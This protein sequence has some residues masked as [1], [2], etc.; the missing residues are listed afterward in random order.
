MKKKLSDN[1]LPLKS[2]LRANNEY[3]CIPIKESAVSLRKKDH[4][5]ICLEEN[6]S[7]KKTNGFEKYELIH[8]AIPE[9]DLAS[10]DTSCWFLGRKFSAPIFI[11]AM[12]GGSAE[13]LR[14]NENLS[15][16]AEQCGIGMGIGSQ[17]AMIMNVDLTNTYCVRHIAPTIFLAGNIGASQI[18]EF[19]IDKIRQA[20]EAIEAD[21]LAI[22]LNA[23][24]E[25]CQ[26]EGDTDWTNILSSIETICKKLEIPV[27]AK[28]TGCG[29]SG[30]VAKNLENA[31]VACI[32]T[33]GAG[34]TSWARVEKI[35]G[36]RMADHFIEW[37]IPTADSL[38]ECIEAV[39][40]PV[41]ASGGLRNGVEIVKALSLGATLT[42]I[43]IPFLKPAVTSMLSVKEK[44]N[45]FKKDIKNT[46]FLMGAKTINEINS[47]NLRCVSH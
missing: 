28:E 25:L 19:G 16:A 14:I 21:A 23:T 40:I 10:I 47:K 15:G 32:D 17:R 33:G 29:L 27:I 6:V 13:S 22:H 8:N 12:T 4:I 43:A 35:R 37:G 5:R 31:G 3:K 11:E 2:I 46:M 18:K 42:G 30:I 26:P 9:I 44:I 24:Q 1:Y 36:S 45:E 38:A 7:F 39:N 34:G 41:I 20:I